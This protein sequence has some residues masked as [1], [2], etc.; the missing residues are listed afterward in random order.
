M[1]RIRFKD[2]SAAEVAAA[3]S[4]PSRPFHRVK[5]AGLASGNLEARWKGS[6]RYAEAQFVTDVVPLPHPSR[7]QLPI[8]AHVQGVYRAGPGEL[9]LDQLNAATRA[10]Q[11][12]ASGT[13][14]SS[15]AI[16]LSV[17]TTDLS[18][19]GPVFSAAGYSGPI[20]VTLKGHASFNGTATGKLTQ[21]TITGNLQSQDFETLIP[22]TSQT[23]E[24]MV[25]WD[26]LRADVQLSPSVFAVHNG[27]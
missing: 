16:K 24:K 23:P 26:A 3:F 9:Q 12:R 27:P 15:A 10:T 1:V 8:T 25:H 20:P 14:S 13:L 4:T 22:A 11:V 18:E 5:L 7:T 6:P 17:I 21:I 2:L 19:W